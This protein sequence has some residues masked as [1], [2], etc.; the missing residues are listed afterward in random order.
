MWLMAETTLELQLRHHHL[1]S[2]QQVLLILSEDYRESSP[3]IPSG[4]PAAILVSRS[5]YRKILAQALTGREAVEEAK[6]HEAE[7]PRN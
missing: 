4:F 3:E 6:S 2:P 7:T 5:A 1:V